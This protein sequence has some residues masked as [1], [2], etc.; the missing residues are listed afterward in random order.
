LFN[1]PF[2]LHLKPRYARIWKFL[3]G[4]EPMFG[5]GCPRQEWGEL[6]RQESS[7]VC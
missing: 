4:Y 2:V 6:S 5:M 3:L 1:F 7:D